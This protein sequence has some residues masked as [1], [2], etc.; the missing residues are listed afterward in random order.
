[1]KSRLSRLIMISN[2]EVADLYLPHE[3]GYLLAS[4]RKALC[5]EGEYSL[6]DSYSEQTGQLE[7]R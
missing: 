5:T 6:Q 1:V 3:L 4:I 7:G 2:E